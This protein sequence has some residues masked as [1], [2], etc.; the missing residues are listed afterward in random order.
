MLWT[1]AL[2]FLCWRL[3]D[4]AGALECYQQALPQMDGDATFQ[5]LRGMAARKLPDQHHIAEAAYERALELE[6]LRSDAHYN[7]GNLYRDDRPL[8][9]ERCYRTSLSLILTTVVLA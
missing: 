6:P 1:V 3:N 2:G 9:A 5:L 8:D 7:L 4:P